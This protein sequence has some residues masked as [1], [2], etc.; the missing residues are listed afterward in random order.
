MLPTRIISCRAQAGQTQRAIGHRRTRTVRIHTEPALWPIPTTCRASSVSIRLIRVHPCSV[1]FM[2]LP[3]ARGGSG[4]GWHSEKIG[5][6][7]EAHAA[8]KL[9][10]RT[11]VAGVGDM[12]GR[13]GC[14]G[15]V[16]RR[17]RLRC[18]HRHPPGSGVRACI[19]NAGQRRRCGRRPAGDLRSSVA[20]PE[21]IPRRG[22]VLDLAAPDHGQPLPRTQA[23][24]AC[25]ITG[26]RASRRTL[27][28]K[29][30]RA[31]QP[32]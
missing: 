29:D 7:L 19:Q 5:F 25:R 4:A 14:T 23:P 32:A 28:M 22:G 27:A 20:K 16:G 1:P 18:A 12:R 24:Q 8:S 9:L 31:G 11:E 15:A 17:A 2:R 3:A 13:T 30:I 10:G 6:I 26:S 21:Q